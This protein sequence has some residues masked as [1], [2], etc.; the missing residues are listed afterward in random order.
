MIILS[1][2]LK[3]GI[4]PD[5]IVSAWNT[6]VASFVEGSHPLKLIKLGLDPTDFRLLEIGGHIENDGTIK[7][8]HAMPARKKYVQQ[9]NKGRNYGRR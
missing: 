7:I 4:S 5:A 6:P 9:L 2:A 8:F 3:H 1:S